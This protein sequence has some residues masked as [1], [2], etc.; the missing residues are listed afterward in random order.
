M[1]EMTTSMEPADWLNVV[2]LL[3]HLANTQPNMKSLP[4][5][6]FLVGVVG[7]SKSIFGVCG[8]LILLI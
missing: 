3:A 5:K 4:E 8:L 6:V 1:E 2:M 7:P